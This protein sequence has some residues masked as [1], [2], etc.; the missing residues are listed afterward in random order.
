MT[1]AEIVRREE[2][3]KTARRALIWIAVVAF[4]FSA[5]IVLSSC[6]HYQPPG[7]D[8]WRAL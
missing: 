5:S 3:R 7:Q 4:A 6:G 8:L 1:N 2:N